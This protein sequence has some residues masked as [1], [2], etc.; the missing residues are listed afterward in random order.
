MSLKFQ[1]FDCS[2]TKSYRC[3]WSS[4]KGWVLFMKFGQTCYL[5]CK[6]YWLFLNS[7][8]DFLHLAVGYKLAIFVFSSGLKMAVKKV[9]NWKK[10]WNFVSILTKNYKI[11]KKTMSIKKKKIACGAF[12]WLWISGKCQFLKRIYTKYNRYL[13]DVGF[14]FSKIAQNLEI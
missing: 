13:S 1:N 9:K 3:H 7:S 8:G 10:A 2:A 6:K 5:R 11:L 14:F 12:R 4:Q